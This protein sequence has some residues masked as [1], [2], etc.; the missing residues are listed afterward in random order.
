MTPF[1]FGPIPTPR[2]AVLRRCVLIVGLAV[3]VGACQQHDSS[4]QSHLAGRVVADPAL[5]STD[6]HSDFRLLVVDVNGRQ[7]D[8]LGHARTDADGHFR[9]PISAPERGVYSLSLW[10]RGGE[11]QLAGTDYV[12]APGDSGTLHVDL[13]LD[14]KHSLRPES[15]ENMALQGYRHAMTMHRRMLTRRLQS[16]VYRPTALAQNIRL[17]SS[18][19]W[20]LSTQ[21]PG[22]YA[23]QFAA[24][25]SLSLL[26]GWNDSLVVARA[27]QI[28]PTSP[29]YVDA[30]RI[31]R[32]AEARR[33]GHRAAL[34][35]VDS[36][37]VRT[38]DPRHQ[39]G[40]KAVRIQAFL[41]SAQV[42]AALSAGQ[43]LRADH[44]RSA[45]AQW[46]RRIEYEA[47]HLQP[48]MV[49]PDLTVRTLAGDTLSLQELRGHPLIL[50]YY[51]P[52]TD[53][54]NLQRPLRNALYEATRPDSVT[55][56]SISVEP[57]SLANRAFLH[58]RRLPGHTV[59][60]PKGP[61]DP[62]V[63]RYNVVH[64]PTWVLVDDAGKIVDRY[65][66]SDVPTLRQHLTFLLRKER[67]PASPLTR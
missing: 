66:A 56:V 35:L 26:E 44:S 15:T 55:F 34:A 39:A 2:L 62:I 20:S 11:D 29:R 27:R 58:N 43:R 32:R 5:S 49:A 59:F 45:W 22:T 12:V 25:E 41:D 40:V 9:M 1:L 17:T 65:F 30:A 18:T 6:D 23:G 46:A 61:E 21:Y 16:D 50:E 28:D 42:E 13:P 7:L 63:T 47:D 33:H 54:Y 38:D 57:D 31:A 4:V 53:L 60:A 3:F 51:R 10:G 36:F 14:P 19:L 52:G 48:G 37:E 24:V 8:T 67:E 64:V